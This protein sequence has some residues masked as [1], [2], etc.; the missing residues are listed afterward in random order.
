MTVQFELT[1]IHISRIS[2]RLLKRK[3][4]GS[5]E[6]DYKYKLICHS[7]LGHG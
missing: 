4:W 2:H 5:R 6:W 3:V 7:F 1:P